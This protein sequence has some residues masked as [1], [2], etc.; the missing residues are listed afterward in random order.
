VEDRAYEAIQFLRSQDGNS[1]SMFEECAHV[2]ECL[3]GEQKELE[4]KIA[5]LQS[6]PKTS[7]YRRGMSF[8][9]ESWYKRNRYRSASPAIEEAE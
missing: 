9:A 3:L 7:A 1:N 8:G 4:E 5:D 6:A 2:I